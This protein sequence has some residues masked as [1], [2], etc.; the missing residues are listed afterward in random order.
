MTVTAALEAGPV[1]SPNGIIE[2][3][4]NDGAGLT[5]KYA[6]QEITTDVK[7]GLIAETM[8]TT[9]ELKLVPA[10]KPVRINENY[11]MKTGKRAVCANA[12][13]EQ[14]FFMEGG[15]NSHTDLILRVYDDGIAFRYATNGIEVVKGEHTSFLIDEGTTRWIQSYAPDSYER[16]YPEMT[17]GWST[18]NRKWAY[19]V[20]VEECDSVFVLI[21]ESEIERGNCASFLSNE[22]AS[23]EYSVTYPDSCLECNG[24]WLSPWRVMII[25]SLADIVESTLVTDVAAPSKLKNTDWIVPGIASWIYWAYNHGTKDYQLL[26]QYVDLAQKMDWRYT[27]IDWEWDAMSNG[28][29][30]EDITAYAAEKGVMP[31]M[32]Y[33][34]STNW[35]GE[36]APTPLYRLNTRESRQREFAWLNSM[37]VKGVKI[38]F[39]PG[40]MAEIMKLCIDIL[41]DAAE[42]KLMV[43][44]HGATIPRGWQR[45]YPNLMSIEGVYGAEWYNNGPVM[46][47]MAASHNATLP[48]T[49]NVVGPM[50]YTP[51][52]FSDS[53][54][55]HITTYAHELAL[56]VLFE[57]GIQHMPDKPETYYSLPNEVK[58]ILKGLPASWDDTRLLA[59]YPGTDVVIAR[60]KG[61]K[62]Y[63][64]GINGTNENRILS[65]RTDRLELNGNIPCLTVKD[66]DSDRSFG[67]ERK[68]IGTDT[69]VNITCKPRGG[70][71][72]V[73]E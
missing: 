40:D 7:L 18:K 28:G 30:I 72:I 16:F 29:N 4:A 53:Q 12:A 6:G 61:N 45:T 42:Y 3:E 37:G 65:F 8:P 43:N 70:F 15:G 5:I 57:S 25:G 13:T 48:F 39:F 22:T 10:G 47:K 34:S 41:E 67:I 50:D 2:V 71:L 44:F 62:W 20:L 54:H 26:K 60:R 23:G 69:T 27:L 19:P 17:S 73:T 55:P 35:I 51:G 66:G 68:T 49:R 21:T 38:D 24:K 58:D 52:T 63:I 59:G 56:T 11:V 32:W 9:K 1:T 14:R 33:N 31:L 36:S 64:A 46:T